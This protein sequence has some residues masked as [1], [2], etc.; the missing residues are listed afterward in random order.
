MIHKYLNVGYGERIEKVEKMPSGVIQGGTISPLLSNIY[1]SAFDEWVE[2][3]LRP[4]FEKGKRRKSN[5]EYTK[6]IRKGK[7]AVKGKLIKP[8]LDDSTFKKLK[9]A[10]YADDFIMGIIGSKEDCILLREKIKEFLLKELRLD[11]SLEKTKITNATADSAVFLGY[12]IHETPVSKQRII[13]NKKGTTTR[14]PGRPIFDAPIAK[15]TKKL[16]DNGFVHKRTKMP[17][18]NGK[19]IHLTLPDLVNHYKAVERGIRNYYGFANNFG[20]F[21]GKIH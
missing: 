3:T 18:R 15:I 10:R 5:P 6:L 1:M 12:R 7:N 13:V 20:R 16:E 9:Y 11:L 2:D 21:A 4:S 8:T 19:F 14:V 17:T